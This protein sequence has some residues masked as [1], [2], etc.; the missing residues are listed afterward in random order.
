MPYMGFCT[1]EIDDEAAISLWSSITYSLVNTTGPGDFAM[2][3]DGQIPT[4]YWSSLDA[5]ATVN[6]NNTIVVTTPSH[7]HVNFGFTEEGIYDVTMQI[8]GTRDGV[9][10]QSAPETFTFL[11]GSS[12]VPEPGTITM[13]ISGVAAVLLGLWRRRCNMVKQA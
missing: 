8:A 7:S 10:M 9:A 5:T 12:T 13:L 6:G 4:A 2:W 3:T 1:K 11:V